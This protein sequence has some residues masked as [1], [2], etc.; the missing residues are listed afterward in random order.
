MD[1]VESPA[2]WGFSCGFNSWKLLSACCRTASGST[3]GPELVEQPGI[4]RRL[5][6][7]KTASAYMSCDPQSSLSILP[8]SVRLTSMARENSLADVAF[9]HDCQLSSANCCIAGMPRRIILY[10]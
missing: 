9:L 5:A 7:T 6:R 10:I 2:C 3:A 1:V 8:L 4:N